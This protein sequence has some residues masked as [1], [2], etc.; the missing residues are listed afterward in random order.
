VDPQE[1]SEKL[2]VAFDEPLMEAE[3]LST[4]PEFPF[5]A[6]LMEGSEILEIKFLDY[7]M[8]KETKFTIRLEATDLAGNWAEIEY[9]FTT[10]VKEER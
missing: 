4:D 6:E 2:E 5:T 3:V 1:Y 7:T 9:T 8:P 10:M